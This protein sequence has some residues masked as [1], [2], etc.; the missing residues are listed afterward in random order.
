MLDC[1]YLF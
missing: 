1:I